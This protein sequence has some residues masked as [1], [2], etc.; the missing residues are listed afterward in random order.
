M[1]P[2]KGPVRSLA[3]NR[4][5]GATPAGCHRR[6]SVLTPLRRSLP[7]PQWGPKRK[8]AST[9]AALSRR[10]KGKPGKRVEKDVGCVLD[11]IGC[12]ANR[13]ASDACDSP[14]RPEAQRKWL[15]H[16]LRTL[17]KVSWGLASCWNRGSELSAQLRRLTALGASAQALLTDCDTRRSHTAVCCYAHALSGPKGRTGL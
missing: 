6:R 2:G 17:R 4:A 8:G 7:V 14:R 5:A 13:P 12:Q 1:K 11:C 15:H 9:A 10:P 3:A 16:C